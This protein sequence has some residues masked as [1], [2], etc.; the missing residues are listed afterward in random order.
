MQNYPIWRT[1]EDG[2]SGG[3]VY[4]YNTATQNKIQVTKN[5]YAM[6]P[7]I[8]ENRVVYTYGSN[9]YMYDISTA[10]TT[11]VTTSNSA[12]GPSIYNDKIVYA[13]SRNYPET[14]EI[15]DIYLYNL[16]P[17]TEKLKAIFFAD[18]TS[19][20]AP[21]NVSFS[22]ISSGMPNAWYWNFGDGT[23]NSTQ[24]NPVHTFSKAG[25]YS[26]TLTVRNTAGGNTV[27]KISYITAAT[28]KP[29][30]AALSAN[31]TSGTAPLT[32]LFSD[33]STGGTPT[34]WEWNFGDGAS[35]TTRNPVHTY[36]KK[37]KFTVSLT[38]G[39]SQGSN[40]NTMPG[41]ITVS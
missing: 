28:L 9:I 30:I 2:D 25:S 41:F 32:V 26:V 7:A 15:R 27:R 18:V 11:S 34:S 36:T 31:V 8:Y 3:D 5:G 21:L 37:G 24:K 4:V 23:A 19:G 20:S 38:A 13:D 16:N 6:E 40:T 17:E 39:N 33:K 14:G 12:L 35:S 1:G 10:K 22:D 29:P